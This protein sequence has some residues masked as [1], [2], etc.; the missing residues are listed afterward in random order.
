[1]C[2]VSLGGIERD[3]AGLP[4]YSLE[5]VFVYDGSRDGSGGICQ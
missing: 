3:S 4:E 1:M 5:Y 2:A